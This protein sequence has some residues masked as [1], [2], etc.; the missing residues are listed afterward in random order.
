M[1]TLFV[2]SSCDG[3]ITPTTYTVQ[4]PQFAEGNDRDSKDVGIPITGEDITNTSTVKRFF[5][6]RIS[7]PITG[8]KEQKIE[9]G[10]KIN[11]KLFGNDIALSMTVAENG[12]YIFEGVNDSEY[13]KVEISKD[14]KTFNYVHALI[15]DVNAGSGTNDEFDV[16]EGAGEIL[17]NNHFDS[18]GTAY[19][20]G[21]GGDAAQY[22]FL[23]YGKNNGKMAWFCYDGK[24][25]ESNDSVSFTKASDYQTNCINVV[26]GRISGDSNYYVAVFDKNGLVIDSVITDTSVTDEAKLQT[27]V[28]SNGLGNVNLTTAG[29]C[30]ERINNTL[31]FSSWEVSNSATKW[32]VNIYH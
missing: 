2:F 12:N 32:N 14:N 27:L 3:E 25:K 9:K 30:I 23:L 17:S 21:D 11:T 1:T 5:A 6:Y 29:G 31:G 7:P 16:V 4:V 19:Y 8:F 28:N 10:S 22:E 24:R 15:L 26:E 13:I 20:L 18:Y